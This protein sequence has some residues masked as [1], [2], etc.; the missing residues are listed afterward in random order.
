MMGVVAE[1]RV[2]ALIACFF[3]IYIA[4]S[5]ILGLENTPGAIFCVEFGGIKMRRAC[6]SG[7]G[8]LMQAKVT[9]L[10]RLDLT[11]LGTPIHHLLIAL[12]Y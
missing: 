3:H 9:L 11:K 7:M 1:I 6:Q 10:A 5:C 8:M 4:L 12:Q 2:A